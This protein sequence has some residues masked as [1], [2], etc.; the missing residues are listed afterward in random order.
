MSTI[1]V[2]NLNELIIN[3]NILTE[4]TKNILLEYC[5]DETIHSTLNVTFGGFLVTNC[6][7]IN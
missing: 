7:V 2:D 6:L 4:Q 3:N 1:D 5:S